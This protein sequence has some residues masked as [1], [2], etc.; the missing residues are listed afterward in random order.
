MVAERIAVTIGG[1][2]LQDWD[3]KSSTVVRGEKWMK[4]A[5]V[6]R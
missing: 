5:D 4:Q 2:A 1:H 3:W 6:W